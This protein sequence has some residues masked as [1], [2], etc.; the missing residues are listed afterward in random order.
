ML[1]AAPGAGGSEDG[2][3]LDPTAALWPVSLCQAILSSGPRPFAFPFHNNGIWLSG[4]DS[5]CLHPVS[6]SQ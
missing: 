5:L 4:S 6:V 2:L 1:P 3:A